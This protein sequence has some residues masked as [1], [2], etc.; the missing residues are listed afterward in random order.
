MNNKNSVGNSNLYGTMISSIAERMDALNLKP[1]DISRGLSIPVSHLR[2][3]LRGSESFTH[4]ELGK[5]LSR[6]DM[7]LVPQIEFE[8]SLATYESQRHTTKRQPSSHFVAQQSPAK[9]ALDCLDTIIANYE[10]SDDKAAPIVAK[11]ITYWAREY[12]CTASPAVLMLYAISTGV[13][14]QMEQKFDSKKFLDD[15]GEKEREHKRLWDNITVSDHLYCPSKRE[16]VRISSNI[17]WDRFGN[18]SNFE[19][20]SRNAGKVAIQAGLDKMLASV[21]QDYLGEP[22]REGNLL[23]YADLGLMKKLMETKAA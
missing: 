13:N 7:P 5:M 17:F 19:T 18:L 20:Y 9:I 11:N 2:G 6:L 10:I 23:I 4:E 22:M 21:K 8:A 3:K 15:I 1:K 12:L 16:Y 14:Y